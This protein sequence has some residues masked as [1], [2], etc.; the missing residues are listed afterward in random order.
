MEYKHHGDEL[1][2]RQQRFGQYTRSLMKGLDVPVMNQFGLRPGGGERHQADRAAPRQPGPG[3]LGACSTGSRPSTSISHLPHYALTNGDTSSVRVLSRQPM[4][5]ERPHP[6][7]A[8][9]NT[10]FNS[11]HLD[12]AE[13]RRAAETS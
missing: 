4:D 13:G 10:E 1:V 3:Q 11:L 5:L 8:A 7:T 9:G 6:F 12:A 2:P